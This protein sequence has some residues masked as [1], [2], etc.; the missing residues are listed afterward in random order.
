MSAS[1][2]GA[3][4]A[5][6]RKRT[7]GSRHHLGIVAGAATLLA[8][9]PLISLYEG[10]GWLVDTAFA[11][12]LIVAAATGVRALRGPVGLQVL[13]MLG[14]LLLALTWLFRSGEELLFLPTTG[15][16]A[17]FG[18]LLDEVPDVVANQSL[19]VGGSEGLQLLTVIGVG[20]I[21]IMVDL[22]AVGM[23]RPALAG[24]PMLAIYS[25]P[26]AV[27]QGSVPWWTFMIGVTG[28]LW[29]ISADNLD[30]VRRFGRR[31]T[32]DGRDV[33]HWEPSPLAAAG[34]RLTV[35]GL[36]IAVALPLVVPG[37]TSGLVDR[38]GN[39]LGGSGEGGVGGSPTAVN[40]FAALDGLL[41]RETTEELVRFTTTDSDPFYLRIGVADEITERG[42]DH[43]APDGGPVNEGLPGPSQP[44]PGVTYHPHQAEVEI[45]QWDMNRLPVFADPTAIEGLDD[46]WRYDPDQQVV[47]SDDT[48][49]AGLEYRFEYQRPQFDP[50]ALRRARPLPDDHPIQRE[51][52]EVLPEERVS[53]QVD[54]LIEGIAS[55]Y[56][57]VLAIL[58][59]FSR[60]NGFSYSLDTGSEVTGSAIVDFLFENRAGFCVQYAAGMAWMVREAGLPARVAVGFSRGSQRTNNTYLLTNHNLHA[61]TEV[62]FDRYGWVPFDATPSSSIAGSIAP[63]WAPDPNAPPDPNA[64]GGPS[65]PGTPGENPDFPDDNVF[66][67]LAPEP[68]GGGGGP[69]ETQAVWQSWLL[70]G[71]AVLLVLLILPALRRAQ[72]RRQRLPRRAASPATGPR[73]TAAPGVV[74][75]GEPAAA[76]RHRAHAVWDELLDTLIDFRVPLN[77]AETPRVTAERVIRECRLDPPADTD[78]TAT[79]R[80]PGGAGMRLLGRAEERARYA[81]Q[82]LPAT[83]LVSAVRVI[84]RALAGQSTRRVRL[85][86]ALLPPS[87]LLHW[88]TVTGDAVARAAVRATRLGD[89][90]ARISPRRLLHSTR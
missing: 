63:A 86:A 43:R 65:G 47:F 72:L 53:D 73:A 48:G 74:T 16:L 84:R 13:A 26:V 44:R 49:A 76:A 23:R 83:G 22:A 88:R 27:H 37:M 2:A 29:L 40:L 55:P 10:L 66:E 38:F 1:T 14:G 75:S 67:G 56:E 20:L 9:A 17:H 59:F 8:A 32:G 7:V 79:A 41:N 36:L 85:Q 70:A 28:Y 90:L 71:A 4:P 6:T 46:R 21:A 11:V 58:A 69:T 89:A 51:F 31:F 61:W 82:P 78:T 62:Y 87:T 5:R 39:G 30:R 54:E 3:A 45:L 33:E 52:A 60:E 64:S 77:P 18:V 35:I 57:Q 80:A 19:P 12:A 15:T 34:R 50:A 81:P 24:L 42:F 68:G 25:V